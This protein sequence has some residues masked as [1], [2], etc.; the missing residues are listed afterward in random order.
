MRV[1]ISPA[2]NIEIADVEFTGGS[3]KGRP[4]F[5]GTGIE[6][7]AFIIKTLRED[8]SVIHTSIL[9]VSGRSGEPRLCTNKPV[10]P[11]LEQK[12]VPNSAPGQV[13]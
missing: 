8:G 2:S 5:Y 11:I 1:E 3:L 12:P 6:A 9:R 7:T 13:G 4:L 10:P